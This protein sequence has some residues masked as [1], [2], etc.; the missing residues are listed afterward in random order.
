MVGIYRRGSPRVAWRVH[1]AH[2]ANSLARNGADKPLFLAVIADRVSCGVDPAVQRRVRN[3][4]S[5]PH[6]RNEVIAADDAVSVF[7]EVNQQ[8]EHLRLHRNHL[9]VTAKFSKI[10]IK[11]VIIE[12][13]FHVPH[14]I[15]SQETIKSV[16]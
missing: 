5:S 11:D 3:D 12:I 16:S 7:Q 6:K 14:R 9:T 10:G 2:E 13:E 4:P 15:F 1:G 8:V